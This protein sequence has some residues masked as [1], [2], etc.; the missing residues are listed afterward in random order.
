MFATCKIVLARGAEARGV[1]R[2]RLRFGCGGDLRGESA[3]RFGFG[4][5][6]ACRCGGSVRDSC[7]K[8]VTGGWRSSDQT[9]TWRAMNSRDFVRRSVEARKRVAT[10]HQNDKSVPL[11]DRSTPWSE[12]VGARSLTS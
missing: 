3:G 5:G 8:R 11:V 9:V 1:E 6:S 2:D 4:A 7:G 10:P 12:L